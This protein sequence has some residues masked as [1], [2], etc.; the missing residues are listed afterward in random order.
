VNKTLRSALYG[1][2][3]L[4]V[5]AAIAIFLIVKFALAPA[6][7]EWRSTVKAGPLSFD[8]GVPTAVR[9]ATS[10]WLAP[11]LD[12]HSLDTRFG[13]VHFAWKGAAGALELRCAPCTVEVPALGT[14][15]I[16]VEGLVATVKRDGN[17]LTGTL[18]ATP[19]GADAAAA[20]HGQW[21]GRL[22]PKNLLL[23]ADIKDAPIARCSSGRLRCPKAPSASF[24]S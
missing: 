2:L 12:G 3:A 8:V 16:Q 17:T 6:P 14:Q 1:L 11:R 13:L 22:T 21:E 20:I 10:S 9:L 24:P 19:R 5:T 4:V 18:E 15:P 7:G 23:S